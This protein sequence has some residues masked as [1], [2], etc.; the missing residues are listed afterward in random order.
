MHLENIDQCAESGQD[1]GQ[2][3]FLRIYLLN[4]YKSAGNY[5]FAHIYR[6][7]TLGKTSYFV[8]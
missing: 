4:V 6:R 2:N 3:F 7:N 5:E 8:K 1:T